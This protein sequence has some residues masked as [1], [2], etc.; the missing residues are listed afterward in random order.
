MIEFLAKINVVLGKDGIIESAT[1]TVSG[2]NVSSPLGHIIGNEY[3]GNNIF[4][5]GV[6]PL[7][8]GA[9]YSD[10]REKYYIGEEL[11]DS[12]LKFAKP[13]ELFIIGKN[14]ETIT[15]VFDRYNNQHPTSI[16]VDGVTYEDDDSTF[17]VSVEKADGH[18][19]LI[20]NWNTAN[21]PLRVEKISVGAGFIVN[22]YN[23]NSL[24]FLVTDRDNYEEPR[25]GIIS[26]DGN[27]EFKDLY[28]EIL[29]YIEQGLLVQGL[30]CEIFLKDT[31]AP[32][33]ER[34]KS[35]G[36]FFANKWEYNQY[37]KVVNCKINDGLVE[38]QNITV[39]GWVYEYPLQ[40]KTLEDYYNY[41]YKATDSKYNMLSFDELDSATKDILRNTTVMYPMLENDTLWGQWEKLCQATQSHIYKSNGRTIFKYNGGN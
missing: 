37:D 20:D 22:K 26:A 29:D 25:W 7:D 14:I 38:W 24:S 30:S 39:D 33:D 15:L 3:Y 11:A 21:Y 28:G 17:T 4:L 18:H 41:L 1:S 27:I 34:E 23:I 16:V 2:N 36:T 6:S 10:L 12:S 32:I 8:N 35:L 5:L 13:Y 31:K 40:P 19:I 9:S